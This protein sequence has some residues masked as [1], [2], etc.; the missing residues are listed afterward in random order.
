MITLR[1]DQQAAFDVAVPI[2]RQYNI[3]YIAGQMRTGKTFLSL[4]IAHEMRFKKVLILTKKKAISSILKDFRALDPGFSVCCINYEQ[5]RSYTS[6][7][8][9]TDEWG[10]EITLPGPFDT[11]RFFSDHDKPELVILDESHSLGQFPVPATKIDSLVSICSGLPIIYLSGTPSPESYS[12]LY[13]QFYVSSYS[14]FAYWRTFYEWAKVFVTLGKK[15]M[16]NRQINDY[17]NASKSLMD[18]YISH[19]IVNM[20]QE[21]AGFANKTV[22]RIVV[23]RMMPHTYNLAKLLLRKRVVVGMDGAVVLADTEVKLQQKLHQ[24]YSGT[25]RC[26]PVPIPGS[27]DPVTGKVKFNQECKCFDLTKA[28]YIRDNFKGNKIAILYVFREELTALMATFGYDRLTDD[29]DKFAASDSL[30]FVS[31]IVSA[32]EGVNLSSADF[33]IMYN[34]SFSALSYIQGRERIQHKDR[35]KEAIVVWLFAE[36]GIEAKIYDRVINKMDYTL[37][38]FKEDYKIFLKDKRKIGKIE[39]RPNPLQ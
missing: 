13:H 23:V 29:P 8:T 19:I 15:Y 21:E 32:R 17:S 30:I 10:E 7:Y 4:F 2:L 36:E 12:Q 25:V 37:E 14:P 33:L 34:I 35:V 11:D 27:E 3:V 1:P 22:D 9:K 18:Q 28:K 16:Y 5:L 26:E 31:Q 38:Y 20:T 24:I 39:N 6:E